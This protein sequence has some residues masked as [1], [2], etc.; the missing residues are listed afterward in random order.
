MAAAA[1]P[2]SARAAPMGA[3]S[4]TTSAAPSSARAAPGALVGAAAALAQLQALQK[5]QQQPQPVRPA[6]QAAGGPRPSRPQALE[7]AATLAAGPL[8]PESPQVGFRQ[9][10]SCGAGGGLSTSLQPEVAR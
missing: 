7:V 8:I 1:A 3:A 6:P 9:V 10:I 5:Q 4:C 2:K